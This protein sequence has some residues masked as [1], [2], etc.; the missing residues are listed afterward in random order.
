MQEADYDPCDNPNGQKMAFSSKDNHPFFKHLFRNF[1]GRPNGL[2]WPC[3]FFAFSVKAPGLIHDTWETAKEL[4]QR[5]LEDPPVTCCYR[6][7]LP[8]RS[9]PHI[10]RHFLT[11]GILFE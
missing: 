2:I 3:M 7:V 11:L 5:H 1:G 8:S 6:A 9:L 10:I 4:G